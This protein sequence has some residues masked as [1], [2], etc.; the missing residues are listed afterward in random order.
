MS[1]VCSLLHKGAWRTAAGMQRGAALRHRKAR[2]C[3]GE[4]TPHF[5]F[6]TSKRKCAVHGGKGKMSGMRWPAKRPTPPYESTTGTHCRQ[7]PNALRRL[8]WKSSLE[9]L[10]SRICGC[11]GYRV[12]KSNLT[13]F[14]LRSPLRSALP[15]F[16]KAPE[17]QRKEKLGASSL[18]PDV[19]DSLSAARRAG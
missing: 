10:R 1:P 4:C 9:G 6:E 12:A 19:C 3:R 15:G 7:K 13:L 18:R 16:G 5:L 17:R 11:S 14:C 2:L 8:R